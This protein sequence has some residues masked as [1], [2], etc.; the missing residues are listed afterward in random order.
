MLVAVC[1]ISS[2]SARAQTSDDWSTPFP[3]NPPTDDK[4]PPANNQT[5]TNKTPPQQTPDAGVPGDGQIRNFGQP[6][7]PIETPPPATQDETGE[8]KVISQQERF[9]E[10]ERNQHSPSTIHHDVLDT[11]NLRLTSS[12]GGT[13]GLLHI[14]SADLGKRGM[15]RIS[16]M[17]EYFQSNNF[18]VRNAIDTRTAG[19]FAAA[20]TPLEWLEAYVSYGAAAN[21]NSRSSPALIQALGDIGLGVKLSNKW[22]K[23]FYGGVDLRLQTF[24]GVG[25]QDVSRYAFGFTP[26]LVGTYD[27][28]ELSSTTPL[29]MHANF[30]IAFDG[31]GNLVRQNVLN[32]SEEYAL[33]INK[34]NRL[35]FGIGAE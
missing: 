10:E 31:T 16:L 29:R 9:I 19:T 11:R 3:P 12:E 14:G 15:L 27:F 35:L 18:P 22:T 25:S 30:G 17:G 33:G 2:L 23:G 7:K 13:V 8:Y 26:R 21:T 6:N 32:S 34:Y 1:A 24:S 28:R 5:Q 4:N 20:M